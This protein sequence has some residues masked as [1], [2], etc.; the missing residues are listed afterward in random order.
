M[1]SACSCI[2]RCATWRSASRARA[3]RPRACNESTCRG[4][5][6][7]GGGRA[8]CAAPDSTRSPAASR[9]A[10]RDR[11][12]T[13]PSVS[14]V[15]SMPSW[16]RRRRRRRSIRSSVPCSARRIASGRPWHRFPLARGSRR[17]WATSSRRRRRVARPARDRLHLPGWLLVTGA[18]SS[19]ARRRRRHGLRRLA[20]QPARNAARHGRALSRCRSSSRSADGVRDPPMRGRSA[21]LRLAGLQPAARAQPAGLPDLWTP[22]PD[23]HRRADRPAPRRGQLR[24]ARR[25]AD[26]GRSARTSSTR[27]ATATGSR[28]PG[29]RPGCAEAAVWG[30]GHGRRPADCHWP[31]RFPVHGRLDGERRRR[32]GG[33]LPGGCPGR[34]HP[35]GDRRRARA[36]RACRRAPSR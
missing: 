20:R 4:V 33:S 11:T 13:R 24:R 22:L 12:H 28:V 29:S 7:H 25:G 35:C 6:Y 34:A 1:Q 19:A 2:A 27:S 21:R 10:L 18:V 26:L 14:T 8:R 32:E 30:I 17:D 9:R 16:P 23:G 3:A 15:R 31:L 36:G 5:G